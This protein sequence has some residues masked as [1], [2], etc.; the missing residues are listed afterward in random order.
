MSYENSKD[1]PSVMI[2]DYG[3]SMKFSKIQYKAQRISL[4]NFEINVV[5]D[6]QKV[7]LVPGFHVR[8]WF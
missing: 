3:S 8:Q 1:L 7:G 4:N 6:W 5:L 2:T